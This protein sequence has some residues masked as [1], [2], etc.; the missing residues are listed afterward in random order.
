M[1]NPVQLPSWAT[2]NPNARWGWLLAQT[3]TRLGMREVIIS[4]GSRSTPLTVAFARTE[5]LR[6]IPVL[7]ERTAAFVALGLAKAGRRPVALVCTSGTAAANY[8]P[9]VIE[10][11][12]SATPLLVLTA[13]RPPELRHC[14][15]GQTIDQTRLYGR[16]PLW[17]AELALPSVDP[18][19]ERHLRQSL[20]HA[21]ERM[22]SPQA[23][24]VHLNVPF[25]DPLAPITGEG[26]EVSDLIPAGF[27]DH[28]E[29][30]PV[31]HT[32]AD[33]RSLNLPPRG[34]IVLGA[35]R[36]TD[37]K[38][39]T[40]ALEKLAQNL[41]WPILA[42]AL[43]PARTTLPS[44]HLV[45]A[46]D[47]FLRAQELLPAFRPD[48]VLSLGPLPTSKILRA[49]L[50]QWD[51][52]TWVVEPSAAN[53]DG[54]HRRARQLPGTVES[55]AASIAEFPR[56]NPDP[57]WLPL[58]QKAETLTRQALGEALAKAPA[59]F[60][61]RLADLLG[62]HLPPG[63]SLFVANSMPVRDMEYFFHRDPSLGPVDIHVNRGANGIDG[64]LGTAL[65]M[66]EAT[67]GFVRDMVEPP[68]FTTE[69]TEAPPGT[70]AYALMGDLAFLHDSNALLVRPHMQGSLT[71][72]LINNEGGGIFEHL[73]IAAVDPPFEDFFAT[74]QSVDF[75]ALVQAHGAEYRLLD[76]FQD[77]PTIL[78]KGASLPPGNLRVIELRTDRKA[79]AAF[80]KETF[81]AVAAQVRTQL[82]QS[83]QA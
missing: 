81:R 77:L 46:Y 57:A 22:T 49:A 69:M 78:A 48:A 32:H 75:A 55:L 74:P 45:T 71:V 60:E 58:W 36:P 28:L 80:R 72:L 6:A 63:A 20:V 39:F 82:A 13:D 19:I 33:L 25:R 52:P 64:T 35:H 2:T 53:V 31:A 15:S 14:Q 24:P 73:P 43:G 59:K 21:W 30:T 12:E 5:G 42:D 66:A 38:T 4:P 67:S 26:T 1:D 3:L 23:G 27:F 61:G 79:D 29:I 76:D 8:L 56:S 70:P 10:A 37:I 9:A 34:L 68:A 62:K 47:T 16:Y 44:G 51:A 18:V 41:R 17:E 83:R 54:L 11:R 7:D 50:S 65:G 40:S